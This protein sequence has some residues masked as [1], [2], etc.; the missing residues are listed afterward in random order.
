MKETR[1]E[2]I[3][4]SLKP[5]EDTL[6]AVRL[7]LP[8]VNF[9]SVWAALSLAMML[10]DYLAGDSWRWIWIA[11]PAV[12]MAV[13][14]A[15]YVGHKRQGQSHFVEKQ[16]YRS[17]G[18]V[19]LVAVCVL[20]DAVTVRSGHYAAIACLMVSIGAWL[21]MAYIRRITNI[22]IGFVGIG[23]A[24]MDMVLPPTSDHGYQLWFALVFLSLIVD[25]IGGISKQKDK[26]L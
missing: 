26:T 17:F 19:S 7:R 10:I 24:M 22:G 2:S 23:W 12:S 6:R 4:E 1:I 13:V 20:I 14:T 3:Q 9:L 11:V 15:Q 16:L 5:I 25:S 8:M 21:T 18:G